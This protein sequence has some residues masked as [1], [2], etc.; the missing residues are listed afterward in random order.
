MKS[1]K[2]VTNIL[3]G[4]V[5]VIGLGI[6][7]YPTIS[8]QWNKLHSSQAIA[9]YQDT[10]SSLSEEDY[11]SMWQKAEEYN[12]TITQNTFNNDVFSDTDFDIEETEYWDVL[13]VSGTG[14]MGYISIPEI[15]EKIPIYHGTS[16]GVLQ[17]AAGHMYGTKL[18]IGG[19]GNHSVIAAHRGL[20]SATLFT[21]IDELQT[22]DKFYIH[23]LDEV[24]AYQVDQISDMI[25]KDDYSTLESLMSLVDGED[26]VTLFTCTPYGINSHRLLVRG[27][28]VAYHGEDDEKIAD[29]TMLES[30]QN[31][32][33]LYVLLIIL[34]LLI[35]FLITWLVRRNKRMKQE[36][37]KT[38]E[39]NKDKDIKTDI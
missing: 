23:I 9:S 6:F 24:L 7:A 29:E 4:L 26:Y 16:E 31:Y 39:T 35:I 30:V 13:N 2:I 32:Y 34:I 21:K 38:H 12:S 18:P 28:R 36:G 10:V 19:S 15:N 14:I 27:T 8:S 17:I 33:M 25:E 37:E 5:F 11:S 1:K 20:P 3:I 22:G